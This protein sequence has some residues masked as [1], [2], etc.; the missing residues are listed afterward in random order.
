MYRNKLFRSLVRSEVGFFAVFDRK[1]SD[2]SPASDR[3]SNSPAVA[4][5]SMAVPCSAG[6]MATN[7]YLA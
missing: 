7:I 2:G 1:S 5:A 4:C 6:L 3:F